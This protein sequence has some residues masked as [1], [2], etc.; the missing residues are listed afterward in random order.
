MNKV[1]KIIYITYPS[2]TPEEI[3]KAFHEAVKFFDATTPEDRHKLPREDLVDK[4][5]ELL[6]KSEVFI[7][8]ASFSSAGLEIEA[9]WAQE[10]DVP[11]LLFVEKGKGYPE[12][13]EDYYLKV[14]KYAD[15][16]ELK[17]KLIVFLNEQYPGESKQEYFQYSDKKQYQGFKKGW[18]RR[19]KK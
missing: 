18:E 10:H 1:N 4:S 17:E 2:E 19:Y 11:I 9:K 5:E 15:A 8:E 6:K 7:A 12:S 3:K 13:L 14:R 16:L